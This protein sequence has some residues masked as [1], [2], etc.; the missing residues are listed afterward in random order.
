M[1]LES[2]VELAAEVVRGE[3]FLV[4]GSGGCIG[5]WIVA[6]LAQANVEVIAGD[7]TTT[8]SAVRALIGAD[9]ARSVRFVRC[10]VTQAGAVEQIVAEHGITRIVHSAALQIPFVAADPVRGAE[11]NVMGTVRVLEAARRSAGQVRG[12]AYASSSAALGT[13]EG[14]RPETLYGVLKACDEEIARFYARD[15]ETPS[16]GLRPCVV[17]GP[18]RDQG[19]TSALTTAIKAAVLGRPFTIPFTGS[20]DAQFT[21]DVAWT[22]VLA[23]MAGPEGAPVFD[24]HGEVVSVPRF[25][26]TIAELVPGADALLDA[27]TSA[28]PGRLEFDDDAE[29][30]ALL[31]PLPKTALEEGIA[32][33]IR[34]Y[35]RALEEGCELSM[36]S[37]G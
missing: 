35:A 7:L 36:S 10:D 25:V 5:S 18:N 19:L 34:A 32:L 1:N 2:G 37:A 22:F 16:V 9:A 33:T 17:Y 20:L 24:L 27:G 14:E 21:R 3:R 31:G 30:Q 6:L 26:E 23:A 8:G 4:T 15:Y 29:L 11:V 12:I 28:L 13:A